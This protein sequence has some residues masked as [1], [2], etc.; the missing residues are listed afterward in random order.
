MKTTRACLRTDGKIFHKTKEEAIYFENT[1]PLAAGYAYF[2]IAAVHGNNSGFGR[3]IQNVNNSLSTTLYGLSF[4]FL[5][6]FSVLYTGS[7]ELL[8]VSFVI[9]FG[10]S[11]S[12]VSCESGAKRPSRPEGDNGRDLGQV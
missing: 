12:A 8:Q 5:P 6:L 11:R 7:A 2:V 4:S 3:D 1:N 10:S 9:F